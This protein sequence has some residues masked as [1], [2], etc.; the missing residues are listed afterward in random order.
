M[1]SH[2]R[3][4]D[5]GGG[6]QTIR[7]YLLLR[8][9]RLLK[10]RV[11]LRVLGNP[12]VELALGLRRLLLRLAVYA[13]PPVRL[14][15]QLHSGICRKQFRAGAV[16]SVRPRPMVERALQRRMRLETA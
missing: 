6:L 14:D 10:R 9:A 2:P 11:G 7:T 12:F 1:L 16:G 13:E 3:D 15:A 4:C 5:A 8:R